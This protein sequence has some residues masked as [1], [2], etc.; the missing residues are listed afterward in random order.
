MTNSPFVDRSDTGSRTVDRLEAASSSPFFLRWALVLV[1]AA[2]FIVTAFTSAR[3]L[4]HDELYTFYIATAP[5]WKRFWLDLHFDLN[6]PLGCLLVRGS[7]TL[8]GQSGFAVRFP[9]I[10][11]FF[12]GSVC[13]WYFVRRWWGPLYALLAVLVVWASPYFSYATEA[14]PYALLAGFLGATLLS[15]QRATERDRPGWAVWLLALSV[16]GMML[17]HMMA[18]LYLSSFCLAELVQLLRTR[19]ANVPVWLALLVPCTIPFLY[20]RLMTRFEETA[21]PPIF[22]ASLH[23]IFESYYGSLRPEALPLLI[24]FLLVFVS[25]KRT[26]HARATFAL[27]VSLRETALTAGLLATPAIVNLVLM[28]SHSAYFDRYALP[29]AFG[30]ALVIVY[31]LAVQTDRSQFAAALVAATLLL[32]VCVFHL[33]PGLK[34][35]VWSRAGKVNNPAF[36]RQRLDNTRPDLPLVT[37]SGLTFLEMDH[38]EDA[39]TVARLFYLTDREKAIRYANATIFESLPDVKNS[40]PVRAHVV[41]F[42]EFITQHREF[43]VLGTPEYPEDWLLRGLL[44]MHETVRYLGNIQSPYKDS[45]LYQVTLELH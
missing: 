30:Y 29:V 7:T 44:D 35:S 3:Q 38:Y 17:S 11:A 43:L 32:F 5:S 16:A 33:G 41:P 42:S 37:A 39:K 18:I 9:S 8:F 25:A 40:F 31:A 2:Y 36:Y 21:F 45:Q 6:P 13:F 10:L 24:G 12:G 28:C 34:E 20:M 22:Q 15:W 19:K 4:W 1:T 14:R 26:T 27:P 23:K